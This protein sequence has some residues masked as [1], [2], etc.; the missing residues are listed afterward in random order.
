MWRSPLSDLKISRG[1]LALFSNFVRIR[2]QWQL[3]KTKQKK[4]K[5]RA[6]DLPV[7]YLRLTCAGPT[8]PASPLGGP[9]HQGH[10]RLQPLPTGRGVSTRPCPGLHLLLR[11]GSLPDSLVTPQRRPRPSR[12]PLSIWTPSSNP[13]SRAQ[14]SVAVVAACSHRDHRRPLAPWPC[15]DL[16]PDSSYLSANPRKLR[17]LQDNAGSP[18]TSSPASSPTR[19]DPL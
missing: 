13:L 3:N 4:N 18:A 6:E 11:R 2:I 17:R 12:P 10:R 15:P 16:R 5:K 19:M 7:S 9:A 8:H 1:V 14:P